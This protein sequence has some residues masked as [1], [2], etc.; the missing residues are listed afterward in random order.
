MRPR[1]GDKIPVLR[2]AVTMCVELKSGVL[3]STSEH[4]TAFV[5]AIRKHMDSDVA[6]CRQGPNQAPHP[7]P[8]V[9]MVHDP[10]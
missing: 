1:G 4:D 6:Q 5:T 3:Y 2:R 10:V 8:V 9:A 7:T